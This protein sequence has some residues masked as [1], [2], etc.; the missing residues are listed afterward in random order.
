M[1]CPQAV[2]SK[3][4]APPPLDLPLVYPEIVDWHG[5]HSREHPLF[6]YYDDSTQDIVRVNWFDAV[7]AIYRI[8]NAVTRDVSAKGPI[9]GAPPVVGLLAVTTGL[10]FG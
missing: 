9:S 1:T 8:A 4:F 10:W 7:Q 3:T 2:G 5:L 6:V